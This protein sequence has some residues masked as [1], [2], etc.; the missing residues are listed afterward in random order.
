MRTPRAVPGGG[1]WPRSGRWR[2]ARKGPRS[3]GAVRDRLGRAVEPGPGTVARGTASSIPG[4]GA[5]GYRRHSTVRPS[6]GRGKRRWA[7]RVSGTR[8]HGT[9]PRP[10][11]RSVPPP[12]CPRRR[13]AALPYAVRHRGDAGRPLGRGTRRQRRAE[14]GPDGF[15]P[16]CGPR[17]PRGAPRPSRSPPRRALLGPDHRPDAAPG[18]RTRGTTEAV[19]GPRAASTARIAGRGPLRVRPLPPPRRRRSPPSTVSAR[20]GRCPAART[21]AASRNGASPSPYVRGDGAARH[22]EDDPAAEDGARLLARRSRGRPPSR[23][24]LPRPGTCSPTWRRTACRS[25]VHDP[26]RE[27][28]VAE[29]PGHRHLVSLFRPEPPVPRAGRQPLLPPYGLVKK[30]SWDLLPEPFRAK[31]S[32]CSCDRAATSGTNSRGSSW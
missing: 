20:C 12:P 1:P 10:A 22:A 5:P 23:P 25:P 7:D 14:P 24:G 28:R 4:D 17:A 32:P 16:R 19:G 13:G 18:R 26:D 15:R 8:G 11:G 27:P 21:T 3:H 29:L 31:G 6:P 30:R 2:G 9:G